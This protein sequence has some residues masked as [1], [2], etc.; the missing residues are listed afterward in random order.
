MRPQSIAAAALSSALLARLAWKRLRKYDLRGRTV[1]VTGGSRGLGLQLARELLGRGARIAI[2]GRDSTA[3]DA[4]LAGL[5]PLGE[6][7]AAPCDVRHPQEADDFVS[8][9]VARFGGLDVIINNAGTIAVGPMNS[10]TM[11]DYKDAL[12]T[13]LWGALHM[14][15]A[16]LPELRRARGRI[17][18]IASIGGLISVPHLLPYNVSKFALV[19]LSEGL[20]AELQ[21]SGV[22]VTTVCPGLM[23]TGSPRNA[24][25]KGNQSSEYAWF[26]L[27]ATLPFS[28]ISA[29]AAARQIIDALVSGRRFIVLSWQARLAARF[30]ANFP[31]LTVSLL[32]L[33]AWTLPK[34]SQ[35]DTGRALG[36][37]SESAITQSPLTTLGRK[38]ETDLNQVRDG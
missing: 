12:D 13:H 22:R 15:K 24:W 21:Q 28:S 35:A 29:P 9:I 16:A 23:R 31:G 30:H 20:G 26:A 19:G 6:V 34:A 1:A 33:V 3:L 37:A 7:L 27:S 11:D 18:N 38:A 25:F 10:M 32:S 17:V 5:Q 14:I 2:C 4:A 8:A 36:S